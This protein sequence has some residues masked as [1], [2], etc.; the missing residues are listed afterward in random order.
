MTWC[1]IAEV[2]IVI[3]LGAAGWRLLVSRQVTAPQAAAPAPPRPAPRQPPS[4]RPVV[5]P[6]PRA[7][8]T[9]APPGAVPT[10]AAPTDPV[11][12]SREM[13]ELNRVEAAF[14]KVEWR[15]TSA[16]AGAIEYYLQHVVLPSIERSERASR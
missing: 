10:P 2:L 1:V 13:D 6:T 8:S 4:P 16:V 7:G 3:G 14:E 12:L 15:I 5:L 11:F 9:A